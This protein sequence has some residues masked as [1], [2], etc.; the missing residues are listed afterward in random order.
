MGE[1]DVRDFTFED[2]VEG[3]GTGLRLCRD[4]G[5]RDFSVTLETLCVWIVVSFLSSSGGLDEHRDRAIT[6]TASPGLSSFSK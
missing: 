1:G 2:E 5:T 3:P 4:V 6:A